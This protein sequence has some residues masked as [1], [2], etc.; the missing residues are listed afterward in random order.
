MERCT[1]WGRRILL[2]SAGFAAMSGCTNAGHF[3]WVD[4]PI[5][6]PRE[7]A[8]PIPEP[9]SVKDPTPASPSDSAGSC[10]RGTGR[11]ATGQCKTLQH[12]ELEF[13]Q[14]IQ[15][16]GGTFV[17]GDIPT[18]Y[19]ASAAR[20]RPDTHWSGNPPRHDRVE[21][22]WI[23]L[24]EVTRRAYGACVQAGECTPAECPE[25][26]A[27]PALPPA[28]E[29]NVMPDLPQTCVSHAQ[30]TTYCHRLGFRLPSEAEWEYAARGVDARIYPWGNELGDELRVMLMPVGGPVDLGYFGLRGFGTSGREW[31]ADAFTLD[32]GL[33]SFLERPFRRADGPL[34]KVAAS[35]S[36]S[37]VV[38]WARTGARAPDSK[39]DPLLGFR[40]AADLGPKDE[41]LEVPT[42]AAFVPLV[43]GDELQI[44]GGVAEAVD[45]AEAQVF[46]RVLRVSWLG[47]VLDDWRL[48]SADDV[49]A[50]EIWFRG[51]GPF[52]VADGAIHQS[53]GGRA[54]GEPW[55]M[56]AADPT[57]PLAARCVRGGAVESTK[58]L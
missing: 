16:P 13:V 14:Q 44:F 19:D 47:Q 9:K 31:V 52:W 35:H 45:H 54:P 50:I 8:A 33:A 3:D 48:P 1:L 18:E 26:V 56:E 15:I 12:R 6:R 24:H 36:G 30:A 51:P 39:P 28:A 32:A 46:C 38:K 4:E 10:G 37:H 23:D 57:E 53:G 43:V 5:P 49:Q 27:M 17:R 58:G 11:D 41:A 22:F 29:E 42:A 40:C 34:R 7:V 21:A 55:Q 2:V 25:G 20:V